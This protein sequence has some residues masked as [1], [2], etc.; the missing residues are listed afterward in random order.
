MRVEDECSV[1][2]WLEWWE[3]EWKDGRKGG[4]VGK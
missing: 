1:G 4:K 2:K 3:G